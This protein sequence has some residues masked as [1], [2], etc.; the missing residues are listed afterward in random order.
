MLKKERPQ[1][2]E[3]EDLQMTNL[4]HNGSEDQD[5]PTTLLEEEAVE[6]AVE[7]VEAVEAVEEAEE[8]EEAEEEHLQEQQETQTIETVAQS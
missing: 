1:H 6:E 3:A 5:F 4:T 2:D 7:V 8:A